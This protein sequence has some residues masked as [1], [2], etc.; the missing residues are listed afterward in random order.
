M[1]GLI[2]P[3]L[4]QVHR[5]FDLTMA[6]FLRPTFLLMIDVDDFARCGEIACCV[7][8]RITHT[9]HMMGCYFIRDMH[10]RARAQTQQKKAEHKDFH[11]MVGGLKSTAYHGGSHSNHP[12]HA[13]HFFVEETQI[14]DSDN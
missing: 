10:K 9:R 13:R 8:G 12:S 14:H 2:C 11:S 5:E 1:G 3:C 7:S 4:G 6:A